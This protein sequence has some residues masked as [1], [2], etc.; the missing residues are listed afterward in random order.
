MPYDPELSLKIKDEDIHYCLK[1]GLGVME[2]NNHTC[3]PIIYVPCKFC[4]IMCERRKGNTPARCF[5]CTQKNH[6]AYKR[7]PKPK[8]KFPRDVCDCGKKTNLQKRYC[9]AICRAKVQRT[10]FYPLEVK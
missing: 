8:P 3:K 2:E 1:C 10:T 5:P 4:G 6:K 7:K 9:G